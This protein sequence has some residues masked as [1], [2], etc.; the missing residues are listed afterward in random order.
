MWQNELVSRFEKA[1]EIG[2]AGAVRVRVGERPHL[3]TVA[4]VVWDDEYQNRSDSFHPVECTNIE[5]ACERTAEVLEESGFGVEFPN[6]R[7]DFL[8]AET[9]KPLRGWNST[10]PINGELEADGPLVE[11][12]LA[13][14]LER[15]NAE[16]RR[17]FG[18]VC[19][20]LQ[21]REDRIDRDRD[22]ILEL[23][24][25]EVLAR[26]ESEMTQILAEEAAQVDVEDPLKARA[27]EILG[28][29]AQQFLGGNGTPRDT[30]LQ[31]LRTDPQLS[32]Q[33][34]TDPEVVALFTEALE[35]QA[36]EDLAPELPSD[37]EIALETEPEPVE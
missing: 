10:V 25:S 5:V 18:M 35:N 30:V 37:E 9:G 7:V 19:E 14:A 2:E 1:G 32:A 11:Q 26:A 16:M 12:V 28:A 4:I 29:I 13:H 20:T 24:R 6:C 15:N 22:E 36:P 31:I 34:A 3:H 23:S 17:M 8:H 27:G 33:L 21:M